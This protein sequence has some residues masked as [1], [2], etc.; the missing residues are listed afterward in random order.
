MTTPPEEAKSPAPVPPAPSSSQKGGE[1]ELT[2]AARRGLLFIP[3]AKAWF[4]IAGLALQ[5]LLPRALGSAALY[6]VWTLVLAWLSWPNNVVV[7]GTIQAV[8]H[9][10][11]KGAGAVEEAKRTALRMNVLI[12]GGAA[13]LFFLLAPVIADFEHDGELTSHLRLASIIVATYSFY[14]VFVG[15][16]NGARQF[17]KQAGLDMSFAA[18]RVGLVL[19]AAAMFHATLPAVG[20]FVVAALIILVVSILWVGLPKRSA[21]AMP[22]ATTQMMGYIAWLLVYLLSTNVLMF[23]DGWWLKRLCTE[24]ALAAGLTNVK[25]MVDALVGVYG[26]AQ[27]VA[28]LP[29]QLILAATFVVFPLLSTPALQAD[30]ARV[31]RYVTATLRY[32]A[33]AMLAMVVALG[34]RPEATLRLLYPAEYATGASALAVLLAAYACYSLLIITGSITNSLGRTRATAAIGIVSVLGT[35]ISVYLSIKAGIASGQQ[36]LRAAALGLLT[37]M[38]GGLLI[39]LVYLWST[40]RVGLPPLSVLRIGVALG[41]TLYLGRRWPAAG[42]PGLLGSKLGT[43]L[44]AGLF[45]LGFLLV[46]FVLREL[47]VKELLLLRRERPRGGSDEGAAA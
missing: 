6:G 45:A 14:A 43:L 36:P 8:A 12:G 22:I 33:V 19:T 25:E 11:A 4:L 24:A 39:S 17:H 42:T 31:G 28:R 46:L 26:A 18:L 44:A 10:A 40:L 7:T 13:I 38:G 27:T 5:V 21:G 47:S 1:D 20:G 23:V 2:A 15:A 9:F 37:G 16:A 34:T 32:S 3:L 29:Y 35:T 30:Q 41:V